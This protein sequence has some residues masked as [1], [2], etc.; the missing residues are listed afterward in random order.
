MAVDDEIELWL[1]VTV[2]KKLWRFMLVVELPRLSMRSISAWMLQLAKNSGVS[3][4]SSKW[5]LLMMRSIFHWSWQLKKMIAFHDR[6]LV[7][8]V[9]FGCMLFTKYNCVCALA[10]KNSMDKGDLSQ[11]MAFHDPFSL[12]KSCIDFFD[13][14]DCLCTLTVFFYIYFTILS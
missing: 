11:T 14:N 12:K 8:G 4:S 3:W 2:G 1:K 13:K 7:G 6:L 9:F 5:W 10:T